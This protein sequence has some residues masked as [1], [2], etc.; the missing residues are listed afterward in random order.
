MTKYKV[1]QAVSDYIN[2]EKE[3]GYTL[4]G[5]FTH[6]EHT[7]VCYNEGYPIEAFMHGVYKWLIN[8]NQE[9]FAKAWIYGFEVKTPTWVI[10][11]KK[12]DKDGEWWALSIEAAFG[13]ENWESNFP[14]RLE[15]AIKKATRITD[16]KLKDALLYANKDFE[17]IEVEE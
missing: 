12:A 16:P 15:G 9:T 4:F 1:P 14:G 10:V 2:Y 11:S 5:A 3:K 6:I 8:G 7:M 17:A 13:I